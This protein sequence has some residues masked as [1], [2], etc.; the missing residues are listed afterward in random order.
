MMKSPQWARRGLLALM[1]TGLFAITGAPTAEAQTMIMPLRVTFEGR[2]R[3][4]EI[5]L[6]NPSNSVAV[7]YKLNWLSRKLQE[8]GNF[9][10]SEGLLDPVFDPDT[11]LVFSPRQVTLPPNG[12]Q[13]LRI[14]LRKPAD[15]PDGEYRAHLNLQRVGV[16]E[17][18]DVKMGRQ[19]QPDLNV[20]MNMN[21]GVAIP[22]I[23]RQGTYDTT[24][25]VTQPEFLPAEGKKPPRVAFYVNRTG[26]F[27]ANGNLKV[28]W[29]KPGGK[30]ELIA[31]R[32]NVKVY[33]EVDRL[34][35]EIPLNPG[36][37]QIAGGKVRVLFE[38]VEPDEGVKFDEKTFT[39]GG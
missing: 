33:H 5:T 26:K 1:L 35:V 22:V 23:V 32:N 15:L 28:Y 25:T 20:K 16:Q 21:F 4:H 14:S 17:R 8:D 34:R 19:Q 39:V 13:K 7:T 38:G 18:R 24:A 27:S 12:K 9:S 37:T 3:M 6:F 2:D 11:A 36:Y 29:Q 31:L 10:Q 30:E